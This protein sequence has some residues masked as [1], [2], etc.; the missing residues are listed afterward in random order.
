MESSQIELLPDELLMKI[1]RMAMKDVPDPDE[2]HEF[3]VDSISKISSRF[4]RLSVDKS[5]WGGQ[6]VVKVP[7]GAPKGA[8]LRFGRFPVTKLTIKEY[9]SPFFIGEY[10]WRHYVIQM[11]ANLAPTYPML[12]ELTLHLVDLDSGHEKMKTFNVSEGDWPLS[13]LHVVHTYSPTWK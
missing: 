11:P 13:G 8:P 3:L 5:L 9:R 6:V 12:E 7:E 4:K 10:N 1:I 2:K